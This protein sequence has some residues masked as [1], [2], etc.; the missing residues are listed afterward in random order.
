[1]VNVTAQLLTNRLSIFGEVLEKRKFRTLISCF[2]SPA[3]MR[4]RSGRGSGAQPVVAS[5][6][7][8]I[9]VVVFMI[10]V[11]LVGSHRPPHPPSH[12]IV[13]P[14]REQPEFPGTLYS[15][16][17]RSRRGEEIWQGFAIAVETW[18]FSLL[19]MAHIL[20]SKMY[21]D[22]ITDTRRW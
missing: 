7:L 21:Y 14:G 17:A 3:V 20:R 12:Q 4:P 10:L 9:C 5:Q 18:L 1:M 11:L 15:L 8:Y 2:Y 22:V 16:W 19:W 6:I 13:R